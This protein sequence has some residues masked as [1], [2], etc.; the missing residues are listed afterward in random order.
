M[1]DQEEAATDGTSFSTL[2]IED[3]IQVLAILIAD[4]L[5]LQGQE[6]AK[7]AEEFEG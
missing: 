2:S 4:T 3:R 6:Q 1:G 7:V 5:V